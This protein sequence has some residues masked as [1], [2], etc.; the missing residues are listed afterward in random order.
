MFVYILLYLTLVQKFHFCLV[1]S[2]SL[3]L[4]NEVPFSC[5][6]AVII[7]SYVCLID[8]LCY[9]DKDRYFSLQPFAGGFNCGSI[10]MVL[11]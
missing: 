8:S 11:T 5:A 1:I 10:V 7:T 3:L 2:E 4:P 9:Y 6:D